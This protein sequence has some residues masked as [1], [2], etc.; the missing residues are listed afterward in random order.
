[1]NEDSVVPMSLAFLSGVLLVVSILFCAD[2]NVFKVSNMKKDC[3]KSL[4]RDQQC[5]IIAV[6]PSKD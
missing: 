3:E 1:M 5:Y 4:P 2:V 6:P